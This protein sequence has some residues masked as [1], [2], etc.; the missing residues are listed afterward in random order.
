MLVVR[1]M[2]VLSRADK[3][4]LTGNYDSKRKRSLKL[5]CV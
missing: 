2:S 4:G 1:Y 3:G 5:K